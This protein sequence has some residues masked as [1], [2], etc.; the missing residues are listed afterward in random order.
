MATLA[1]RVKAT[2]QSLIAAAGM[3]HAVAATDIKSSAEALHRQ[4][5]EYSKVDISTKI[6]SEIKKSHRPGIS[7]S[8]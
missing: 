5:A 7:G 6:A 8:I 4:F 1:D 3:T 2:A